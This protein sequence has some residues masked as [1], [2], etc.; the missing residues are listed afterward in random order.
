[1]QTVLSQVQTNL[2]D[3][4]QLKNNL[5]NVYLLRKTDLAKAFQLS[6][7][8]YDQMPENPFF[9]TTHAYSLLLQSKTAEAIKAL[10]TLKPEFLKIPCV[11]AYYGVVQ[12]Q[13]GHKDLAKES[14][15]VA[16]TGKL[17]PEEKELVRLAK[18]SL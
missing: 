5:A 17:L 7:E 4:A 14:L 12:A 11:A 1:M 16:A 3:D 15:A 9:I 13:A 2:P 10:E 8:A 6:K 18:A